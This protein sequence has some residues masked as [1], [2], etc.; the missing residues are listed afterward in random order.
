MIFSALIY[1]LNYEIIFNLGHCLFSLYKGKNDNIGLDVYGCMIE[2][3]K[4]VN[5]KSNK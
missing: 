1:N 5:S 2:K 4:I 3:W